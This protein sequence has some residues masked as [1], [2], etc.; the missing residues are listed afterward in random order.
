MG[1]TFEEALSEL[2]SEYLTSGVSLDE[3]LSAMED[4]LTKRESDAVDAD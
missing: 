3:I 1:K 4:E 2:V